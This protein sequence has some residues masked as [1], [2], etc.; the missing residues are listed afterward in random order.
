MKDLSATVSNATIF[1][2]GEVE[3]VSSLRE[4]FQF[5]HF[6]S[7]LCY[8]VLAA[9][10]QVAL[11]IDV[12]VA[13]HLVQLVAVFLEPVALTLQDGTSPRLSASTGL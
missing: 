8:P 10:H 7:A 3:P 5:S 11:Y 13:R 6:G 4:A 12:S 2:A 9:P 1:A